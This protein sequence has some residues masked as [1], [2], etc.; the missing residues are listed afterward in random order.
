MDD[1]GIDSWSVEIRQ[2][3]DVLM[4]AVQ[5][6]LKVQGRGAAIGKEE[7]LKL[8]LATSALTGALI[9]FACLGLHPDHLIFRNKIF[10]YSRR[11]LGGDKKRRDRNER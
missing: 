2:I 5:N 11:W 3:A 10:D 8:L 9:Q 6:H 1:N 7:I 4:T